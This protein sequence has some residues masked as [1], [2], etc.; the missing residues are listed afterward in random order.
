MFAVLFADL[1]S[2]CPAAS[3][4]KSYA[5]H[6]RRYVVPCDCC[7][8]DS[9]LVP[10]ELEGIRLCAGQAAVACIG[11]ALACYRAIGDV[12]FGVADGSRSFRWFEAANDICAVFRP[13]I[14][15]WSDFQCVAALGEE[16]GWRGLL[17]PEMSRYMSYTR[18][19]FVSGVV[20]T[21]WHLPLILF[22]P[23]HGAGSLWFSL[24]AF[25]PLVVS[26]SFVYAW[27][28][29]VSGSVWPPMLLH[30]SWNYFV[31]GFFPELTTQTTGGA[32][33]LGEF[34]WLAPLV[35]MVLALVFWR[36]R[37][38]IPTAEQEYKMPSQAP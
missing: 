20:W 3:R 30:G 29:L 22:G 15:C 37:S 33:M 31:Q 6:S 14:L 18:L 8:C 13:D 11:P 35:S 17:V 34:G 25:V 1:V 32:R 9:H 21:L 36:F 24:L 38:Y 19:A 7:V 27:M 16:L 23:Y 12:W 28:R 26:A 5:V 10:A 2:V 4:E